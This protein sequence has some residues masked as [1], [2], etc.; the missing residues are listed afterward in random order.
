MSCPVPS[1]DLTSTTVLFQWNAG[2]QEDRY[3]L[4]VGTT[5]PGSDDILRKNGILTTSWT[6][7]GIPTNGSTV[8]VRLQWRINGSWSGNSADY[9]YAALG[10]NGD[11]PDYCNCA[12]DIGSAPGVGGGPGISIYTINGSIET[13]RDIDWFKI[14]IRQWTVNFQTQ[15]TT[16]TYGEIWA[17]CSTKMDEDNDGG[18][19]S[20]FFLTAGPVFSPVTVYLRVRHAS[21]NGTGDYTLKVRTD[22]HVIGE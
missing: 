20:N 15:G 17:N 3:R 21:E 2:T 7:T 4:R 16:D 12:F 9:T 1:S 10:G 14:D 11:H 13:P 19:G 5:G 18:E 6:V 22:T 8:Y